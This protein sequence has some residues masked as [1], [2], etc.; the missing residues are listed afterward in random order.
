MADHLDRTAANLAAIKAEMRDLAAVAP[1][2]VV[3]DLGCGSG[4]DLAQLALSGHRAIGIDPSAQ[5][6]I[7]SGAR[8]R[9]TASMDNAFRVAVKTGKLSRERAERLERDID[10]ASAAGTFW[11]SLTRYLASAVR[12]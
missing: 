1:G 2:E 11:A 12:P 9:Q 5:L 8:L 6:G 3:L 10:K 7:T 4:H